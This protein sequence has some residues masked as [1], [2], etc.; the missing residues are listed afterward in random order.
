M[1]IIFRLIRPLQLLLCR[2]GDCARLCQKMVDLVVVGLEGVAHYEKIAA[3]AGD[4]VPVDDVRKIAALEEA[5]GAS[6]A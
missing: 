3:V 4:G 6:A 2:A 1:R 5:K